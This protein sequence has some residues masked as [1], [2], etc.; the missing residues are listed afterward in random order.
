MKRK[1]KADLKTVDPAVLKQI[2]GGIQPREGKDKRRKLTIIA[3]PSF[4]SFF[5]S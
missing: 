2:L 5:H 3:Q 1:A 4:N